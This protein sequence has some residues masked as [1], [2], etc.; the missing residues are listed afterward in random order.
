[1]PDQVGWDISTQQFVTHH[2]NPSFVIRMDMIFN[3]KP[4]RW[5]VIVGSKS[6]SFKCISGGTAIHVLIFVQFDNFHRAIILTNKYS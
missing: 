1:M 6:E 5:R 2:H 3:N 4:F